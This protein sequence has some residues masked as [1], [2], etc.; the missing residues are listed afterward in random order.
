MF[1]LLSLFLVFIIFPLFSYSQISFESNDLK[2][3]VKIQKIKEINSYKATQINTPSE[4]YEI[5][6]QYLFDS[7]GYMLEKNSFY[8]GLVV[9][10]EISRYD[11]KGNILEELWYNND[12]SMIYNNYSIFEFDK[13]GN[14]ISKNIYNSDSSIRKSILNQY[15]ENGHL[16]ESVVKEY[17]DEGDNYKEIYTYN[18][19][20]KLDNHKIISSEGSETLNEIFS[21]DESGNVALIKSDG[22]EGAKTTSYEYDPAN[23]LIHYISESTDDE[24]KDYI[25]GIY[26][27]DTDGKLTEE[28]IYDENKKLIDKRKFEITF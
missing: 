21:Y 28:L 5:E 7:L 22:D 26:N 1:K 3:K 4:N 9:Q 14:I 17:F 12:N 24:G 2:N 19:K 10:K 11:N 13:K 18:E 16:Q 25:E 6:F 20:G 15:D 27:Y 23:N 8:N